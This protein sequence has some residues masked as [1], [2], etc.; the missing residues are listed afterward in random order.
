[1]LDMLIKRHPNAHHCYVCGTKQTEGLHV[2]FFELQSKRLLTIYEP[3]QEHQ[4]YPQVLHGGIAASLLDEG[5]ARVYQIFHQDPWGM[6]IDLHVRYLKQIPLNETLYVVS[7]LTRDRSR[8]YEVKGYITS[9]TQEIY[10]RATASY[11][12]VSVFEKLKSLGY[13][14]I[15]DAIQNREIELPE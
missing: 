13:D 6:T 11:I 2:K 5:M 3:N 7:E 12:K 14:T 15:D 9:N 1:M 8:M 4:G 10:A